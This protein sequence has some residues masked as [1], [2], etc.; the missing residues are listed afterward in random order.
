MTQPAPIAVALDAPDLETAARWAGLV[1]P[2]VSTVKVGLELYLRYG[3]GIVASIRGA[4]GVKIFLDLKLHDIPA[5]VAGAARAVARLHPEVLTVHAVGGPEV[6][7]AAVDVAPDTMI[8]AVTLLTS[9]GAASTAQ[10]ITSG[11]PTACT[12]STSGCSRAT[13]RAAP[14]TVAGMS[15]S[16]RSR[17]ILTPLAPR[18]EATIPGPYRR[19]SSR[20]T[21]TVLTC[22]VTSPAQRAAVSRFGASS[23]TAIGAGWVKAPPQAR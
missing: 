10:R 12:V 5:T 2:H 17:K 16:L 14:V 11:P 18:I 7:R 21:L 15:C 19:Y 13:A 3:P 1:T 22:G 8:A 4:S 9:L 6:I 20:P 23:A